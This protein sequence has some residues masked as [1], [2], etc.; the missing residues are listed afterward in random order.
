[1]TVDHFHAVGKMPLNWQ[2][3]MG[4]VLLKLVRSPPMTLAGHEVTDQLQTWA[5]AFVYLL[6]QEEIMWR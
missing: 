4:T 2:P 3:S 1:M 6:I 5:R